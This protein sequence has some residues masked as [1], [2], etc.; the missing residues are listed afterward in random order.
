MRKTKKSIGWLLIII[1]FISIVIWT[2]IHAPRWQLIAG[3]KA[4]CISIGVLLFG[5]LII[6]LFYDE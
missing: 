1:A 5:R 3:A 2:S 6:W 4:L